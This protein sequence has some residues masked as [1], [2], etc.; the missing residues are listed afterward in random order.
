[1]LRLCFPENL[2]PTNTVISFSGSSSLY[3]SLCSTWS[4]S[5]PSSNATLP[6]HPRL[7]ASYPPSVHIVSSHSAPC[8]LIMFLANLLYFVLPLLPL[9][10][11]V[12]FNEMLEVFKPGALNYSTLS[13]FILWILSVSMNSTS[14][15]S[16]QIPGYSSL[17]SDHTDSGSGILS[18]DDPLASSDVIIFVRQGLFDSCYNR[19]L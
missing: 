4:I 1:M 5:L 15:S 19:L 13:C 6:P 14:T 16:F 2:A 3:A 11:S 9:N 12:F 18:R 8:H 10:C 7:Q 17:R